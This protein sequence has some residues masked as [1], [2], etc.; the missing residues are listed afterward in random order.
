VSDEQRVFWSESVEFKSSWSD[1]T[2]ITVDEAI[3]AG[4]RQEDLEKL[5]RDTDRMLGTNAADSLIRKHFGSASIP[6]TQSGGVTDG[7]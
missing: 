1:N 7:P 3:A 4:M 5:W 2:W 6:P